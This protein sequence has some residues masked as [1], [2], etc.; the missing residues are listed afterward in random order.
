MKDTASVCPHCRREHPRVGQSRRGKIGK[1]IGITLG[2]IAGLFAIMIFIGSQLGRGDFDGTHDDL[3]AAISLYGAGITQTEADRL[4][5]DIAEQAD[6]SYSEAE[7]LAISCVQNHLT[8]EICVK[9]SVVSVRL[10]RLR[11]RGIVP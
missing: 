11:D 8:P 10:S 9:A 2:V 7:R 4:V 5:D 1:I 6:V 3:Y